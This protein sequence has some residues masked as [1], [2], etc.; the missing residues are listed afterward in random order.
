[1]SFL[2]SLRQYSGNWATAMWAFA[3]GCEAKLDA[4]ITKPALMQKQ[5]LTPIV[6][7]HMAEVTLYQLLG[8][9]CLHSQAR[10]LNSVMMRHLG[11]DI[12]RYT[13]REAE[14]AFNAVVGWNFG[15]AHLHDDFF[16]E[17]VRE[18]CRFE[19]GEFVVVLVES[20]PILDGRQQYF[21][22]DS[23]V[24]LVE[25]GSWSVADA[26][27]EQPWLPNGPIPVRVDWRM[28]GYERVSHP[29]PSLGQDGISLGAPG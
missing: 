23:G 16:L 28:P 21:V 24:G 14:F 6:G 22:W 18:R 12:D 11:D 2:I 4:G 7:E 9:R 1:V 25:R 8:W 19:P 3:P 10:G 26:V 15:D 5:Q 13:L 27:E 17:A 20:E 29:E